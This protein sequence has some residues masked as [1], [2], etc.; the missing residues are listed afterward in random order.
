MVTHSALSFCTHRQWLFLRRTDMGI[1]FYIK[2]RF[3]ASSEL[4][5]PFFA[6]PHRDP[7]AAA[8]HLS[9]WSSGRKEGEWTSDIGEYCCN[10]SSLACSHEERPDVGGARPWRSSKIVHSP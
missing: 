5:R 9:A 10:L 7:R 2:I 4:V 1:A 8:V 6:Y 3:S